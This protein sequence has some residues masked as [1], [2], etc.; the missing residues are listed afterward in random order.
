[1]QPWEFQLWELL[2]EPTLRRFLRFRTYVD[3]IA[4]EY[5]KRAEAD[6][7]VM[8]IVGRRSPPEKKKNAASPCVFVALFFW[9][10]GGCDNK[11]L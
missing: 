8:S 1:M 9:F 11:I 5:T 7:D 3:A 10:G 2:G 4:L 6:V